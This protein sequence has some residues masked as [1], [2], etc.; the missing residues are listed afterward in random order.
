[1]MTATTQQVNAAVAAANAILECVRD[2]GGIPSGHLYARLMGSMSLDTYTMLI[3]VLKNSGKIVETSNFLT[4]V[5]IA[6]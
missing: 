4:Y 5:E 3:D 6:E 1:M 2:T